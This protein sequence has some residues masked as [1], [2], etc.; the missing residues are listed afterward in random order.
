MITLLIEI[1]LTCKAWKKG[2]K[3]WALAPM[4]IGFV[5]A[6]LLGMAI[7]ANGGD[8]ESAM[9]IGL[10]IDLSV[11]VA[12]A[13]MSAKAPQAIPASQGEEQTPEVTAVVTSSERTAA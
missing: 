2:W 3:G 13:I 9:G 12:L 1:G 5:C 4:V 11:I 6:F 7:G 10:L 8:P